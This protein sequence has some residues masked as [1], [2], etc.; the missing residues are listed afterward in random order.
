MQANP[1]ATSRQVKDWLFT[2]GSRNAGDFYLDPSPDDTTTAYWTGLY[3]MRDA[4]KRIIY[5]NS[6]SDTKPTMSGVSV[7]GISFTQS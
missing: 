2:D 5:D 6:A 4:E 3:N 1:T 7:S